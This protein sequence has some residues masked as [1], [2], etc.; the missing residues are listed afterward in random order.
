MENP[1]AFR[2][3]T[4]EAFA[5][6]WV[7]HVVLP[8]PDKLPVVKRVAKYSGAAGMVPPNRGI[9]PRPALRS[10]DAFAIEAPGDLARPT[11]RRRYRDVRG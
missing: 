4:R 1:L 11:V 9:A 8:V 3:W 6:S 7:L 2:V 5:R 10:Q